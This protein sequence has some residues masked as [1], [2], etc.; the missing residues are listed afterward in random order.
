MAEPR[1]ARSTDRLPATGSSFGS[2]SY[3]P[4]SDSTSAPRERAFSSIERASTIEGSNAV[5]S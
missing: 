3:L 2:C 1:A 5:T 4:T